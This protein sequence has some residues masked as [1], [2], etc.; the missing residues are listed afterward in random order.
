MAMRALLTELLPV[1]IVS[2]VATV[3]G[4]RQ[5]D[6]ICRNFMTGAAL[7]FGMLAKQCKSTVLKMIETCILP[8]LNYVAV[9]A[10][11]TAQ[12]FMHVILLMTAITRGIRFAFENRRYVAADTFDVAVTAVQRVTGGLRMIEAYLVPARSSVAGFAV[13]TV[14]IVVRIVF[15]MTGDASGWRV[16]VGVFHVT[17]VAFRFLMIT[18]Q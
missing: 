18:F 2:P 8:A 4:H 11:L 7:G 1:W 17:A 10:R 15:A 16:L 12:P 5:F 3:T 13:I 9:V 6:C 14:V